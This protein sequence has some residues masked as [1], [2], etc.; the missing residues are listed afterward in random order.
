ME[1]KSLICSKKKSLKTNLSS[2]IKNLTYSENV[3]PENMK[4]NF[5]CAIYQSKNFRDD[6]SKHVCCI[7]FDA[8]KKTMKFGRT[9]CL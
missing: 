2:L 5:N 9:I 3:V 1:N 8:N 4:T 6:S 7:E